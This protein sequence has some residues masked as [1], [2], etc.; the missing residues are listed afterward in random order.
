MVWLL[1]LA[2]ASK[3]GQRKENVE[4]RLSTV[5]ESKANV[6]GFSKVETG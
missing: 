1:F 5:G 3:T 6:A 4:C 2:L